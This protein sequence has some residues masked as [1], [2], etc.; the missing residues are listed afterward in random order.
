MF[1]QSQGLK[2]AI[3]SYLQTFLFRAQHISIK[4]S[5]TN[6]SVPVPINSLIEPC[7]TWP[8]TVNYKYICDL[9][10]VPERREGDV[11]NMNTRKCAV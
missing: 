2:N 10:L 5:Q 8:H 4:I 9:V 3:G 6:I 7:D 11:L 1:F